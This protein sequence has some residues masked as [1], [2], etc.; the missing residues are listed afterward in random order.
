M[1]LSNFSLLEYDPASDN[2]VEFDELHLFGLLG[3]VLGGSV[4]IASVGRANQFDWNALA[5]LGHLQ[6]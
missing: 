4:K 3:D 2:R 5:S 6:K 1:F